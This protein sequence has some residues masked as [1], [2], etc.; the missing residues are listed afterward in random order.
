MRNHKLILVLGLLVGTTC[1]TQN[2]SVSVRADSGP[3]DKRPFGKYLVEICT[4][5][6]AQD[7]N[8][9]NL[10]RTVSCLETGYPRAGRVA[11]ST[12][13]DQTITIKL[14]CGARGKEDCTELKKP[15]MKGDEF[16][17]KAMADS[18]HRVD[19]R[20]LSHN[21][22]FVGAV[23]P[24]TVQYRAEAEG[25]VIIKAETA[26]AEDSPSGAATPVYLILP[27]ISESKKTAGACPFFSPP[28]NYSVTVPIDA[29]TI[30]QLLGNPT[31][32]VLSAQGPNTIAIYSTRE[33]RLNNERNILKSFQDQI[34]ILAGRTASSLGL[35]SPGKSFSVTLKIPHAAALG[36][37]AT[38]INGL[39]YK[40]FTAQNVGPGQVRITTSSQPDCD[41]WAGF[42][43]DIRSMAWKLISEPMSTKLYYLS[44]SDLV[45]GLK[46][47]PSTPAAQAAAPAASGS[48]M[49]GSSATPSSTATISVA[50]PPGS[51]VQIS[52]DT[53]PCV[54]AGL[55]YGNASACAS[56]ANPTAASGGSASAS[57]A[58]AGG[59]SAA[60]APL[61]MAS[62]PVPA[63][64]GP[65]PTPDLIVY[66]DA[67][68]GDDAQIQEQHRVIALLDLPRPELIVN[69]WVTQNS[70]ASPEAMGAFTNLVHGIVADYNQQ[71][72]NLVLAGWASVKKQS[73]DEHYFNE[74][75]RSYIE[76]RY[77]ADRT[78]EKH[79]NSAQELAQAFLDYGPLLDKSPKLSYPIRNNDPVSGPGLCPPGRYCLGYNSLFHPLKPT[80][81]DLLLTIIAAQ[82]PIRVADVA[83]AS[84]EKGDAQASDAAVLGFSDSE[85]SAIQNLTEAVCDQGSRQEINRCHAIWRNLQLDQ[86]TLAPFAHRTCADR[87]Y[88]GVLY[89][90][91]HDP[92]HKP[93][94]HL[95]CF[96][97][98][99]HRLLK[100]SDDGHSYG[101]GLIRA[102]I[103]DF[104][105]NYKAS[106]QYP[107]EFT[108]YDLTRSADA[109]NSA[110]TPLID[111]FN[112]DL[113]TYQIFIRADMQY[114]VERLNARTDGRCCVK[115]LF[116]IDKPSF[117]ND[118]L[119]TVR[120][121]SGQATTVNTTSQS[122][123]NLSTAPQLSDLLNSIAGNSKSSDKG[124]SDQGTK[125]APA[126]A[127]GGSMS[128]ISML[129]RILSNYQTT[130]AQIGR[131]LNISATPRSLS[132]AASAEI[133][134]TLNAD[135]AGSPSLY[136]AGG[137]TSPLL[138]MSRVATHETTTRVRVDSVKLFEISSLTAILEHSRSRF[139]LLPPF[140]EIPYIG[141][142]AGIPLGAAKEFHSSTAILSAYVVPTATDI[143]Y[144]LR[145]VPD[146]VVDGLNPGPCSFYQGAAGPEVTNVCLFRKALSFR[147]FGP[148]RNP[149]EFNRVMVRCFA[150]DSPDCRRITFDEIPRTDP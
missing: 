49:P 139:P 68:P 16:F 140:V 79:G 109:V 138:N 47:L 89:S 128:E 20:V 36:D 80:L 86:V 94:I 67:N 15:V 8:Q 17:V 75:F 129:S 72:E 87:D 70:S 93:R 150:S 133:S 33:P 81:T 96:A 125:S 136:T 127:A 112:R 38:R 43:Q 37:V 91:F 148:Q 42:L 76:D 26:E 126:A 106:Q 24:F 21:A 64:T 27:V 3:I 103:A 104:L 111:A 116:G 52:S 98:E 88:R 2:A 108:A 46:A 29:K 142:L 83:I 6:G 23:A 74:S 123:L 131:S 118:G 5:S 92:E 134:V 147:D 95:Q 130:T 90:L 99:V 7:L 40:D 62:V 105:Y 34:A 132:T 124:S 25:T 146:L 35:P 107:H 19:Q 145:F 149:K 78:V 117:F 53:T 100:A 10:E 77:A 13:I 82:N 18:G 39:N 60:K 41:A 120:T 113:T 61:G 1:F 101:T 137:A 14:V 135:E 56:P 32:F 102:A 66:S 55:A 12:P 45:T 22:S 30:V 50:Q 97:Q 110:L 143:A 85:R 44:S 28:R 63:V 114:Q 59:S 119:V 54:V 122:Y 48:A 57:N 84:V 121:I 11:R 51:N 4:L 73:M 141:T 9:P 58:A 71:F 69:A 144:G 31:P 65:P 115:R